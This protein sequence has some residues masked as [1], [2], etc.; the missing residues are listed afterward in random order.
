MSCMAA[1][2]ILERKRESAAV[3]LSR[4]QG[5]AAAIRAE[6]LDICDERPVD[7][8][9]SDLKPEPLAND[10]VVLARGYH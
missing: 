9:P 7:K 2:P 6:T 3:A 10:I 1:T 5:S 8:A 4:G